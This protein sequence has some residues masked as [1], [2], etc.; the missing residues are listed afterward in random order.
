MGGV[1]GDGEEKSFNHEG[2]R[3]TRVRRKIFTKGNEGNEVNE[4]ESELSFRLSGSALA[5]PLLS[6]VKNLRKKMGLFTEGN[7]GNEGEDK[8]RGLH[9]R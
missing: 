9:R 3:N 5:E 8:K 2:T 4:K 1:A 6:F 7:E